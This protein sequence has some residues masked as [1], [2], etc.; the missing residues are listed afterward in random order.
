MHKIYICSP[1]RGDGT[2]SARKENVARARQYAR[3]AA[4]MGYIPIA[5]HLY[6]TQY[7]DDNVPQERQLGLKFGIELLQEC[8]ELWC[9]GLDSPSE[10]MRAE[11]D[12]ARKYGVPVRDGFKMLAE[13]AKDEKGC[14]L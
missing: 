4:L 13:R 12:A 9:F 11:L 8:A 6:F 7:L 1:Y 10:G 3:Q 5:P 2:C 14:W